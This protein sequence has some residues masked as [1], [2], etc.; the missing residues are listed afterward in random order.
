MQTWRLSAVPLAYAGIAKGALD[1]PLPCSGRRFGI[2]NQTDPADCMVIMPDDVVVLDIGPF[3]TR[4]EGN[5][6]LRHLRDVAVWLDETNASA[7]F[8]SPPATCLAASGDSA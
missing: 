7:L 4:I 1:G 5:R 2:G 8:V 6:F 3:K